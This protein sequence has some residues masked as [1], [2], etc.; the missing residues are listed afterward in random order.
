MKNHLQNCLLACVTVLITACAS[1]P[2]DDR[3]W[4]IRSAEKLESTLTQERTILAPDRSVEDLKR[5]LRFYSLADDQQ[6]QARCHLKL[7]RLHFRL[8]KMDQMRPHLQN[9]MQIAHRLNNTQMQYDSSLL[10]ARLENRSEAFNK[11]LPYATKPIHK[12]VI[13]TY[14]SRPVEAFELIRPHLD[15]AEE[16]ADDFAFVLYHYAEN[17]FDLTYAKR[18]LS[19]YKMTDNH[20]GTANSLT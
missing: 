19:L 3:P 8:G 11:V 12:A 1:Q 9:A 16:A 17:S 13:L 20:F 4:S 6:S 14:L 18:A 5:A 15:H 10:M 2:A 7:A